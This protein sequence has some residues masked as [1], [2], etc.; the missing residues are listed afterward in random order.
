[1]ESLLTALL[2]VNA[3]AAG[4]ILWLCRQVEKHQGVT[5][6]S[7]PAPEPVQEEGQDQRE[8]R[9]PLDEGFEN[10]M[11]YQV[12]LGRGRSTGGGFQ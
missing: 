12:Q 9:L 1:M 4:G 5:P 8:Q 7:A 10:L 2:A 3:C 11:R 6:P